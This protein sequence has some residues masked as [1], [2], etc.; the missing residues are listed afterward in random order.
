MIAETLERLLSEGEVLIGEIIA[1]RTPG[2]SFEVHHRSEKRRED[3]TGTPD[4]KVSTSPVA[5]RNLAKYD[6]L[7]R[8]RPLKGA[9]NLPAGW[10]LQ[11]GSVKELVQALDAFYP[12]ALATWIAFQQGRVAPVNLRETLQRQSGMYRVTQK[13]TNAQADELVGKC[14]RSDGG[15]LRTIL[16]RLDA[17]N[18]ISSLPRAKF[19]PAFDQLAGTEKSV[20]YLC[21]E[22]CNILVAQARK[23]VKQSSP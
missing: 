17:Q 4:V 22:A 5:A 12:G 13:M 15:C 19:N 11:L 6:R 10:K 8:Y 9:P 14:C 2:G 7:G 23:I 16:W 3:S 21:V 18:P 1:T 20:P